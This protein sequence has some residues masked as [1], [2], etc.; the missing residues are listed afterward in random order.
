[1]KRVIKLTK[2]ND[3]V[4]ILDNDNWELNISNDALSQKYEKEYGV[5]LDEM[6]IDFISLKDGKSQNK[7][8]F[9][10]II[11]DIKEMVE[12]NNIDYFVMGYPVGE[13]DDTICLTFNIN[14][15][16]STIDCELRVFYSSHLDREE[17]QIEILFN[18]GAGSYYGYTFYKYFDYSYYLSYLKP[19][20][21]K[22]FKSDENK[23]IE[24]EIIKYFISDITKQIDHYYSE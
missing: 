13:A 16:L 2:D 10:N 1:M 24:K 4:F 9:N 22:Y 19:L 15:R 12:A 5:K 7:K 14:N 23:E 18:K 3:S 11:K 20:L 8:G 6:L 21:N 17:V